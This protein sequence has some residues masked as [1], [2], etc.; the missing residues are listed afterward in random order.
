MK[1]KCFNK[2]SQLMLQTISSVHHMKNWF[3]RDKDAEIITV[4][5]VFN[6][7]ELNCETRENQ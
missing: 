7:D 1:T 4:L 6:F 3:L 5:G 2:D